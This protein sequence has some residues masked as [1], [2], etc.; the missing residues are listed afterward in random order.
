MTRISDL[1]GTHT[2][3]LLKMGAILVVAANVLSAVLSLAMA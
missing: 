2:P 1:E 3:I